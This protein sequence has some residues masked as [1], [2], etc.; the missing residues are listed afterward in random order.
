MIKEND[1][2]V[3]TF[4]LTKS[5]ELNVKALKTIN[6]CVTFNEFLDLVILLFQGHCELEIKWSSRHLHF[7]VCVIRR[8]QLY[9]Q[10]R[11]YRR[12]CQQKERTAVRCWHVVQVSE[13]ANCWNGMCK[14]LGQKYLCNFDII[15]FLSNIGYN[16]NENSESLV[17]LLKNIVSYTGKRLKNP[18]STSLAKVYFYL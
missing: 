8:S 7:L 12:H 15:P 9:S 18:V 4:W 5:V 16:R 2:I 1:W 17:S 13:S 14:M 11:R 10:A 6:I 3:N